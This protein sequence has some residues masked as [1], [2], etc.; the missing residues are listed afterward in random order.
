ML[1]V[2]YNKLL[3]TFYHFIVGV[4][5]SSL[6]LAYEV[7]IEPNDIISSLPHHLIIIA[8]PPMILSLVKAITTSIDNHV[9]TYLLQLFKTS[10]Y[11]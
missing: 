6:D 3:S 2:P 10:H 8:V 1:R 9:L 4:L 7:K 11:I 5:T